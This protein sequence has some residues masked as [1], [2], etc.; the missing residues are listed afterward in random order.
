MFY[1]YF[2]KT[3]IRRVSA[4]VIFQK[5]HNHVKRGTD[6][7]SCSRVSRECSADYLHPNCEFQNHGLVITAN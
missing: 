5:I 3:P 7:N 2:K 1:F 4:N 6:V